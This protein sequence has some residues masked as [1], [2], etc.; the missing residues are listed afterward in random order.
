MADQSQFGWRH[1]GAHFR[2][3]IWEGMK[4]RAGEGRDGVKDEE[5]DAEGLKR[6]REK[7][8]KERR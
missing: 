3:G 1:R 8:R 6:Q 4:V 5:L 7:E 2:G